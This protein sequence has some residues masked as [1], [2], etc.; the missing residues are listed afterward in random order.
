MCK[1]MLKRHVTL[2]AQTRAIPY[3]N[4]HT[5]WSST[6]GPIDP[7]VQFE[8][9]C[10]STLRLPL[11]A[12]MQ[13][14]LQGDLVRCKYVLHCEAKPANGCLALA[15]LVKIPITVLTGHPSQPGWA[16]MQPPP[17]WHPDVMPPK[18]WP[19]ATVLSWSL[20]GSFLAMA[21]VI[22]LGGSSALLVGTR[23]PSC[24]AVSC[25]VESA[26]QKHDLR[27]VASPCDHFL[28]KPGMLLTLGLWLARGH[29]PPHCH[30]AL[31][32]PN[33]SLHAH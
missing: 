3:N 7:Q 5:I 31:L 16:P 28:T 2:M 1:M 8:Q 15:A 22:T 32:P 25:A 12:A 18:V 13:P 27:H 29:S 30:I 14:T 21:Q 11:D 33:V 26:P 6:E 17:D 24:H 20:P 23:R 10:Q 4:V 19:C 9:P